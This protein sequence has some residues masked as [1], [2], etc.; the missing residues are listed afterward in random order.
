[1]A[2]ATRETG[3]RAGVRV[4]VPVGLVGP[5]GAVA[6]VRF[7]DFVVMKVVVKLVVTVSV[8][9]AMLAVVVRVFVAVR[10]VAGRSVVRGILAVPATVRAALAVLMVVVAH[11][12]PLPMRG[13]GRVG[14]H[15][16]IMCV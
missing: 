13:S 10:G 11:V 8:F 7:L 12:G 5:V 6:P 2:Q 9:V 14:V 3:V 4:V 15:G 16:A 1:M